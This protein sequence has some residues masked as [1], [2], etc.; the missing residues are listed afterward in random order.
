MGGGDMG[1]GDMGGTVAAMVE[2]YWLDVIELPC[3]A[4]ATSWE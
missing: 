1:G 3:M 2:L 4:V